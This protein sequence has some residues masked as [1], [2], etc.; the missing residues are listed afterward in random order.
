MGKAVGQTHN[1]VLA[2][3]AGDVQVL[4]F[5]HL[6]NSCGSLNICVSKPPHR[7]AAKTLCATIRDTATIKP[8]ARN[9]RHNRL[10]KAVSSSLVK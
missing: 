7:Q 1:K 5:V 8:T 9:Q 4:S 6:I 10:S 3:M 2:N